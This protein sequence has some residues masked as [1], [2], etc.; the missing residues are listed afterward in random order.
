MIR[1][2]TEND[3]S[4][5]VRIYEKIL[6]L[7]AVGQTHTGWKKG[8]YPTEETAMDA[9]TKNELFVFEEDGRILA[10]ARINKE[11]MPEY[12][13]CHWAYDA[14]ESEIMV[15]HTL[16]V[17]PAVSG[18]G[19]GS[20]FISFYES[21]ASKHGC[22]YLRLDTSATNA[23]ARALYK[24]L[25]YAEQ[26]IASCVFNGIDDAQLVCLEKKL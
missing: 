7:E 24:K 22:P 12:A 4:M 8:I 9:L 3:I 26:G 21:F 5:V 18:L 14:P 2:A 25:G 20:K 13:N 6:E 11:Q 23:P 16:A 10:T 15:I 19:I 1:M 17:D